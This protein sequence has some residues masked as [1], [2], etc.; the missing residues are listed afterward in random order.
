MAGSG[1][2]VNEQTWWYVARAGGITAWALVAAVTLWGLVL[3]TRIAKG[4]VTPAWLL[5]LHR[6]LGGLAA[7]FTGVHVGG[8]V[9]DSY[10][11][12]TAADVLVP[13]ASDWKPGAVAAGVVSMHLLAAVEGTSLLQKKLPRRWWRRVHGLSLPL[14]LLASVHTIAAGTDTGHPALR[15]A[16]VASLIAFMFLIA[17]RGVIAI[18]PLGAAASRAGRLGA[19]PPL[20][21]RHEAVGVHVVGVEARPQVPQRPPQ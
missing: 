14:Y 8:L 17:Y 2:R 5:D 7:V 19:Q 20:P 6:Y 4:K 18:S 15:L 16:V 21:L 11:T 9:A 1:G 12:F 3:S 13:F 10:V